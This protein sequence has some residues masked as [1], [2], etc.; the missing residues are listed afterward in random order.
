MFGNKCKLL[1]KYSSSCSSPAARLGLE[2]RG[3]LWTLRLPSVRTDPAD[4]W[5]RAH[6]LLPEEETCKARQLLPSYQRRRGTEATCDTHGRTRCSDGSLRASWTWW[7]LQ[8]RRKMSTKTF[9]LMDQRF[10]SSVCFCF[11]FFSPTVT[12][13][14]PFVAFASLLAGLSDLSLRG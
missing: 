11:G 5:D 4:L 14:L 9:K 13:M 2:V 1:L 8:S 10:F 3:I 7:T 6:H 12:Y